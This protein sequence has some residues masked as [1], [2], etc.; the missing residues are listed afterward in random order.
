MPHADPFAPRLLAL[1]GMPAYVPS[2]GIVRCENGGMALSNSRPWAVGDRLT[3]LGC[4]VVCA[5]VVWCG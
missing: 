1:V 4:G 2:F 5:G 3:H